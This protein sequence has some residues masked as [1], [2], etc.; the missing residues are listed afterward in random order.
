MKITYHK[1]VLKFDVVVLLRY[2]EEFAVGVKLSVYKNLRLFKDGYQ[3]LANLPTNMFKSTI[4]VVFV[5][6][7]VS[8]C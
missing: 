5:N 2:V 8:V 7:Y 4:R 3:Q 6:E 1:Y